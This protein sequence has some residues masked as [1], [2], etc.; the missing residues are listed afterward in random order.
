MAE[1]N[2][3]LHKL[4]IE[5]AHER[6][7]ALLQLVEPV[8]ATAPLSEEV[9]KQFCHQ[10]HALKG[11]ARMVGAEPLAELAHTLESELSD[12][13]NV[14]Q[15]SRLEWRG[16][17]DNLHAMLGSDSI[18]DYKIGSGAVSLA[19]T[20]LPLSQQRIA[21]E[22]AALDNLIHQMVE[23]GVAQQLLLS[24]L[25]AVSEELPKTEYRSLKLAHQR[26][27]VLLEA[28][29]RQLI[30]LRMVP[31]NSGLPR[32]RELVRTVSVDL[33]RSVELRIDIDTSAQVDRTV[34]EQ[35]VPLVE[36]LL[37]N[38]ICHGIEPREQR[39]AVGK[40]PSGL[41]K[42]SCQ[43][44]EAVLTVV[45]EDDGRGIDFDRLSEIAAQR[46]LLHGSDAQRQPLLVAAL[47]R[48]GLSGA[49][50]LSAIAGR[51]IGLAAVASTAR[52]LGGALHLHSEPGGG[53]RFVLQLPISIELRR[54]LAV[55]V[56]GCDY[57]LSGRAVQRVETF[58]SLSEGREICG[59]S[60]P[61]A[62]LAKL[63]GSKPTQ[64][65]HSSAAVL[66]DCDGWQLALR[67]DSVGDYSEQRVESLGAPAT[68]IPGVAG[69]L[70]GDDG[71]PRLVLDLLDL[72]R[73]V[74]AGQLPLAAEQ[75]LDR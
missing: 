61:L 16:R 69:A 64:A 53:S 14:A 44:R 32:W 21:V 22:P 23:A 35:L 74:R 57:L 62:D 60:Y 34:L 19:P 25:Q 40:G 43:C 39:S 7:A 49:S 6:L 30:A 46:G 68:L 13:A 42:V 67:V 29:Q 20:A 51:G 65:E 41:I 48:G 28:Q 2:P 12:P 75:L 52:D 58:A 45:V 47:L 72:L 70:L 26:Q 8:V 15:Q 71:A 36:H 56:G 31:I 66:V 50:Q 27:L 18:G 5:E 63:L 54:V 4:F 1:Q 37:R 9:V 10:L 59:E 55:R 38:A 11:S 33:D 3:S 17:I 73:A 24:Q